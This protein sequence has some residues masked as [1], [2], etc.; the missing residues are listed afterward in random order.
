M[1][2]IIGIDLGTTNCCVSYVDTKNALLP[3]VQFPIPQQNGKGTLEP[4]PTLPSVCYLKSPQDY[5]VGRHALEL[6][7]KVPTQFIQSAKSWLCHSSANRRDKILPI[8]VAVESLRISPVEA[9]TRYLQQIKMGWNQQI[10]KGNPDDEFEQ[11]EII[12]TVPASFDEVARTL[13]AEAAKEAGI[14]SM[15]LLEEPQA[16]FYSWISQHEKDWQKHLFAGNVILVVDVGG[17][18]TDFS[19][20]EVQEREGTLSFQRMAVGNHLLLG[21][22]NMDASLAHL[23]EQKLNIACTSFQWQHLL[24]EARKA[25]EALLQ[26]ETSYRVLLQGS[27][28]KVVEGSVATEIQKDEVVQFLLQGFFEQLTWEEALKLKK[29]NALRTMGLPYEEETSILRHLA[30][31]LEQA[32]TKKIDFLLFNGGTMKPSIFQEAVLKALKLWF[33]ENRVE[34]LKSFS[35]DL[36]VGRGAAYY[37]KVRRGKGIQIGGG[38]ARGFYLAVEV[39]G[40][41]K[42][43][44]ILPRGSEEGATFEPAQSFWLLPNTPITF[45]SYN[46][47]TRLND[48]Q[49]SLIEIDSEQMQPLPSI[50][51][52]LNFGKGSFTEKI[53]VK[54]SVSLTSIGTLEL[55]LKSE[56][57]NHKWNLEFQL[58]T[59]SGQEDSLNVLEKARCDQTFDT[60]FLEPS[61][62]FLTKMF[63]HEAPVK[64]SKLM[65]KL[66]ELLEKPRRDW[67]PS[68]LR[69]LWDAVG[70]L[71]S[72]R[73]LS[74]ELE[75]RWWNLAG[76]LLRPGYGYPLDDFRL[77][78]LW[79]IILSA[80][81]TSW[82]EEI[83]VQSWICQRRIAG[84]LNKGQQ[85]QLANELY[86]DIL[87]GGRGN[88]YEEK[89][90]AFSA[91]ERVDPSLKV[92]IGNALLER[93]H[94]PAEFWALGR[95]GARVL[96]RGSEI[97]VVP[98]TVVEGWVEKLLRKTEIS[99]AQKVLILG[100]WGRKT[101]QREINLSPST[102]HK[103]LEAYPQEMRLK[104]IVLEGV[105]LSQNEQEQ[106]FGEKL[107]LGLSLTSSNLNE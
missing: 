1:R 59:A 25:K 106:I 4:L 71:S 49:G 60:S 78:E 46:S 73:K 31:F 57:S 67:S 86:P 68:L 87:K 6:G 8:E 9:S 98:A 83:Q 19:L 61:K 94:S 47:H 33:P 64:P 54:L 5:F 85:M 11:Q 26:G 20:I 28:S 32:G 56:K 91:F 65:E 77:K 42:A 10:A 41:V 43:M 75:A 30:R 92:K 37:G 18:T 7:S 52:L 93:L 90:R 29:R 84:G 39:S 35:L 100:Q 27:G 63:S 88:S 80:S 36:A 21:G 81:K 45:Q 14:V 44:T 76:F 72:K 99:S 23:I 97:Q 66:E 58:R 62:V 102:V 13:T 107:P 82:Q 96:L 12:L 79:K 105:T 22:D 3:I 53:P 34:V 40:G 24:H 48:L 104:E 70:P 74:L 101:S 103:I 38:S 95:L 51:T 69:G 2:Y 17:G 55:K 89:L 15:T 50:H 16:A